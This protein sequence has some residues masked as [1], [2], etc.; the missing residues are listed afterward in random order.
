MTY[1]HAKAV[2]EKYKGARTDPNPVERRMAK[3]ALDKLVTDFII[4]CASRDDHNPVCLKETA[5]KV[6]IARFLQMAIPN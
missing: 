2:L 5:E 6:K 1:K 3:V 4:Y